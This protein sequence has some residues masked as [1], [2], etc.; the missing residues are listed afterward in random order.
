VYKFESLFLSRYSFNELA[1][2][3]EFM[4]QSAQEEFVKRSLQQQQTIPQ[5]VSQIIF[6]SMNTGKLPSRPVSLKTTENT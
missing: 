2:V 6:P 3:I 1:E 4:M 5:K